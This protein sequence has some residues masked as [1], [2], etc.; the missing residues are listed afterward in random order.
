MWSFPFGKGV[1]V[2]GFG[3][4][5]APDGRLIES[6]EKVL[7]HQLNV[8]TI[9]EDQRIEQEGFVTLLAGMF[10]QNL[11]GQA[12]SKRVGVRRIPAIP[13]QRAWCRDYG[14]TLPRNTKQLFDVDHLN[15]TPMGE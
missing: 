4:R 15:S 14:I 8:V 6:E 12:I 2:Y 7:E 10:H 5:N 1:T 3:L 9:Q 13:V 11:S